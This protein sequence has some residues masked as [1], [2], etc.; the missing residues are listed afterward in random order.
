MDK[1]RKHNPR[2]ARWKRG[3]GEAVPTALP[4]IRPHAAGIDLDSC[5]PWVC[6][7]P[8]AYGKPNVRVFGT[9]TPQLE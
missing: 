3:R 2:R 5:E 9:T 6:G 7:P 8:L 1:P 4:C